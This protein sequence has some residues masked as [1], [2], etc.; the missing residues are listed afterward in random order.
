MGRFDA[1]RYMPVNPDKDDLNF[2][3][4]KFANMRFSVAAGR[5]II[6]DASNE[7]NL[8]GIAE[9]YFGDQSL[10]WLILD[11][12]GLIDP[13]Q[14]IKVGTRLLLPERRSIIAFLEARESNNQQVEY[15]EL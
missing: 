5:E 11:Y 7:A 10:W 2:Y 15:E 13:I 8:P 4:A 9:T 3:D 12:N 1:S 14:D 6:V